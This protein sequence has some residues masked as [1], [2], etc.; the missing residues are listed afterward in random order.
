MVVDEF[1]SVSAKS[2]TTA[3]DSERG[4][5]IETK[6]QHVTGLSDRSGSEEESAKRGAQRRGHEDAG[7]NES[8]IYVC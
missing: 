6:G 3:Q 4:E 5:G 7:A 8:S 2:Q 1:F